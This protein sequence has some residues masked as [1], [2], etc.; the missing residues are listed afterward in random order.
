MGVGVL[1]AV[2][3]AAESAIVQAVERSGGRLSVTRRCADLTEL[4]AA[5]EAG[6]GGLAVVSGDLDRFD[7]EA[8]ATLHRCGVRV[9][10]L[11][12][13]TRP[14]LA[15]RLTAH[16]A[17][18]VV[19][20]TSEGDVP[21]VV[22]EAL[23]VLDVGR[24]P[25]AAVPTA[26]AP[27]TRRGATVAVWGPTGAP[28]RTF[29][30]VNLAAEL[31]A[32]GR[33]TLL[34]DADTY[35]GAV[36]QVLGVLD[37]APGIAAAARAAGQGALDLPTLARLAPVVLPGLRLLSGISR[38]ARW[39]ELPASSLELVLSQARAL[40]DVTVVDTGFCLEQDE[41]L[42]YDT[43]APARNAATV[44]A[45][46][47]ADLV[48]VVGAADPVGVQ[49]LVRALAD[50]A[51]RGLVLSRRVVVNRVRPTVAGS[52][53][54][55]AVAAALARYAGVEDVVLVPEDRAAAD[56][57]MLEGRAL[58]EVVPGSP[59]RRSLADLAAEVAATVGADAPGAQVA[60][61]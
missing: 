29:V 41:M 56:A 12:D 42:S 53:P 1:C 15:E 6:L 38:A 36:A 14:W 57:A 50:A 24:P 28:G 20:V 25:A 22:R 16:G 18:L 40:A 55:E 45:L 60:V 10:G 11:G 39:P 23:A 54:G 59:A 30:A 31:A 13:A 2:Q 34:V 8:V 7:R 35:G 37:E 3:G 44:T 19:D 58:R 4:L 33:S 26:P 17:D 48:V 61:G 9:V 27:P 49:R 21:D 46:E 47:Q 32:L 52:R 51:E 43:R 5:A